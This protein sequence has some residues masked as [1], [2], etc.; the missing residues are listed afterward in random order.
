MCNQEKLQQLRGN[1]EGQ[2]IYEL[3]HLETKI[4]TELCKLCEKIDCEQELLDNVGFTINDTKNYSRFIELCRKC[5]VDILR[6]VELSFPGNIEADKE[7]R[8]A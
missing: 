8:K 5:D 7:V 4:V 1:I 6:C 2:L 3:A